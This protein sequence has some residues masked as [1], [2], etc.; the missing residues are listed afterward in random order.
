MN[1]ASPTLESNEALSSTKIRVI[2]LR[3]VNK[4]ALRAIVDVGLGPSLVIRE[5]RI[6]QQERQR[7]WVSAPTR[8]WMDE[9]GKRRFEPLI[10]LRGGL[11]S[12]VEAAIFAA[13]QAEDGNAHGR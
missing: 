12:R 9:T 8:E 3:R 11:K 13:W 7:P 2:A 6:V 5:F 10:E 4:G 1:I